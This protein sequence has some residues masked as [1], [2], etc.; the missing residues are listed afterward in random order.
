[1]TVGMTTERLGGWATWREL[2]RSHPRRTIER[3]LRDGTLAKVG[4]NRYTLP[5]TVEATR[6]AIRLGGHLSHVSA[7]LH[8]GWKVKAVPEVTWVTLPRT[9]GALRTSTL[10]VHVHRSDLPDATSRARVTS[11]LRTVLDC[12]RVLPFDE[13]LTVADSAL[14]SGKV[15]RHELRLAGASA[16]GPGSAQ[17]RRVAEHADGRAAN[18]LE[19]VLRA[20]AIEVGLSLTPQLEVAESGVYARVDL[21]NEELQLILEAEGYETHGTRKGLRRDCRRHTDFAVHGWTSMRYAYEHVM[22]EQD[23]V[24]WSLAAWLARHTGAPTPA[25]PRTVV[26][27]AA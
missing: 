13:A 5:G 11:P 15:D 23:W 25:R 27:R 8:H 21:G 10:G 26:R 17:V 20:L 12:A 3:A 6:E 2:R 19:S 14:R 18:P 24:R 1:M 7:A 22:F 4:H 16:R 9:R